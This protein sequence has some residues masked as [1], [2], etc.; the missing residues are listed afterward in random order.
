MDPMK[1]N[2]A[3]WPQM[4]WNVV[5]E[6][7]KWINKNL[8]NL[9][10]IRAAI[11]S[12]WGR[13]SCLIGPTRVLAVRNDVML[14]THTYVDYYPIGFHACIR[15]DVEMISNVIVIFRLTREVVS[16]LGGCCSVLKVC[17]NVSLLVSS[18]GQGIHPSQQIT[19]IILAWAIWPRW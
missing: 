1:Y 3:V 8:P 17:Y 10:A 2:L 16:C 19:A 9:V 4:Y 7:V 5:V 11:N 15:K 12:S 14:P 6:I 13:V 18:A